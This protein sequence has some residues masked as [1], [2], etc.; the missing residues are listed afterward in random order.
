MSKRKLV[1]IV[2]DD[3]FIIQLVIK[4]FNSDEYLIEPFEYG[5]ECIEAL[6]RNPDMIILDYYFFKSGEKVLNGMEV[7]N[8]IKEIKPDVPVVMLS[9]QDRGD[10][11]LEMARMG[12]TDYIIKDNSLISNLEKA[13]AEILGEENH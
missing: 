3:P 8:K 11:V 5:E 2:D 10:V 1:F 4:R 6:H 9:G 13:I 12:I 7:Y